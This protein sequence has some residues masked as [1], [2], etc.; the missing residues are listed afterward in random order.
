MKRKIRIGVLL[1]SAYMR[2]IQEY[3]DGIIQG[4]KASGAEAVVFTTFDT[5]SQSDAYLDGE[6]MLYD[7]VNF[8]GLDGVIFMPETYSIESFREK[9]TNLIHQRCHVPVVVLGNDA[10]GYD[11]VKVDHVHSF[12]ALVDHM[13]EEHGYQDI[14][15]LT[16]PEGNESAQHRIEGFRISLERHGRTLKPEDIVY[17]DYWTWKA[18][19]YAEEIAQGKVRRPEAVVCGNDIMALTLCNELLKRG[20]RVPQDVA[21]AGYDGTDYAF[22]NIPLVTSFSR[23]YAEAGKDAVALLMTKIQNTEY[24][25]PPVRIGKLQSGYTCGCN[26]LHTVEIAKRNDRVRNEQLYMAHYD[27]HGF[28]DHVADADTLS[29]MT[30]RIHKY[31]MIPHAE[32]YSICLRENW[33]TFKELDTGWDNEVMHHMLEDGQHKEFLAEEIL[34]PSL[35]IVEGNPIYYLT[36]IHFQAHYFGFA[37]IQCLPDEICF[38]SIYRRFAQEVNLAFE[39]L[40]LRDQLRESSYHMYLSAIRDPMTGVV[41]HHGLLQY[42]EWFMQN[43]QSSSEQ[44]VYAILTAADRE[45]ADASSV[46]E[47]ILQEVC[48]SRLYYI[49]VQK[50]VYLLFGTVDEQENADSLIRRIKETIELSGQSNGNAVRI[51]I[52]SNAVCV[53]GTKNPNLKQLLNDLW[54]G[55]E[56]TVKENENQN[57]VRYSTKLR[58]MRTEIYQ[59]PGEEWTVET[60]A[61]QLYISH[62][63]FHRLYKQLFQVTFTRDLI[64]ARI[65]CAKH[66]LQET[67]A[68]LTVIAEKCGYHNLSHFMRQFHAETNMTPSKFRKSS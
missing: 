66:L 28:S 19:E 15:C 22:S 46:L 23:A 63:H 58:K 35:D 2:E 60:L 1:G 62:S 61:A 54:T 41:N 36:P 4:V 34:P 20:V 64:H 39:Q 45:I 5:Y 43:R 16:G 59:R 40:R 47:S 13:I 57:T 7:M 50:S 68:T 12:A 53:D 38:N 42:L 32:K 24:Q 31:G 3:L 29:E 33:R 8:D 17:G 18:T 6:M 37:I 48:G 52:R 49:C 10:D 44:M 67:D 11:A 55:L 9:L 30:R 26:N 65:Q 14:V 25:K 56:E 51:P 27:D 21:V